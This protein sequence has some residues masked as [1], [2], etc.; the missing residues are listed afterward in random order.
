M[1]FSIPYFILKQ[2]VKL[3]V[4]GFY[5]KRSVV[6][7]ENIPKNKPYIIA[8]NHQSAFMDPIM[9]AVVIKNVQT[10]FLVRADIFKKKWA[11]KLL[12]AV[13]MMPIYRM[14]DGVDT[15][16]KNE[17]VF[18]ACYRIINQGNP[19]MIYPEGNHSNKKSLRPL[20]KG[21]GRIAFGAAESSNFELDL[22]VIPSGL[23]YSNHRDAGGTLQVVFAK[24]ISVKEYQEVYLENE[25]KA[26]SD[27]RK[28]LQKEMAA[29]IIDIKS[30]HYDFIEDFRKIFERELSENT[31]DLDTE[32]KNSQAFISA[33][34]KSDLSDE[35]MLANKQL[36]ANIK[37][38]LNK[39]KI[40]PFAVSK[41]K[42]SYA[43]ILVWLVLL[44]L[45]LP[46]FLYG[47]IN[48]AFPF[49]LPNYLV[50]KKI[51]DV[52]FHSSLK[53]GFAM[54]F[55]VVFYLLQTLVFF[56]FTKDILYTSAYFISLPFTGYFAF[57][58]WFKW[59]EISQKL[60]VN[61]Y[62]NNSEYIELIKNREALKRAFQ[63][64]YPLK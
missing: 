8:S 31:F 1:R 55:F 52:H 26:L 59:R 22:Q 28:R 4:L 36:M 48:N 16:E 11:S 53:M 34:Q 57:R 12:H 63:A 7:L 49:H 44:I 41:H 54:V 39:L 14:R 19:I 56:Y 51:K 3:S 18:Q 64:I 9:T 2:F 45:G 38:G 47:F 60:K 37:E 13:N 43:N 35:K 24:G 5:R 17:A 40:K 61:L 6:G 27:F 10:Y 23:N 50:K 62:F 20:K 58:Y 30:P 32:I 15:I 33:F 21:V 29:L 42:H 25:A 46:L